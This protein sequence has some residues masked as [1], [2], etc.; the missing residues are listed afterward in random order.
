MEISS[1]TGQHV[2]YFAEHF[3]LL[4]FHPS[5]FDKSLFNSIKAYS[6]ETKTNNVKEPVYVDVTTDCD[7]WKFPRLTFDYLIN[8]NMMHI[9]PF[10]CAV[11]L[12]KNAGKLLKPNGVMVTYGPYAYEGVL[13]PQSNIDFDRNLRAQNASWGVRDVVDLKAIAGEN[14]IELL[15]TYDLPANNKCLVWKKM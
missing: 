2:S 4:T 15:N 11:M 3:P 14:K 13:E 6:C 1:G 12:F 5:E 9:A 10:E 8:I 7:S